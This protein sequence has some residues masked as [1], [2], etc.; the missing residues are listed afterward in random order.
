MNLKTIHYGDSI[1]KGS[2][3]IR[4]KELLILYK[5]DNPSSMF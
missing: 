2:Y 4:I 1:L 5:Y 3:H